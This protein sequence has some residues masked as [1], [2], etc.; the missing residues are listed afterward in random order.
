[1]NAKIKLVEFPEKFGIKKEWQTEYKLRAL[2]I[3][4]KVPVIKEIEKIIKKDKNDYKK[5]VKNIKMQLNSKN[6]LKNKRKVQKGKSEYQENIIEIKA[7]KGHSRLFGFIWNDELII[8]TNTYWKTTSKK[9]KQNKAF[10]RAAE[11]RDL[12]IT[13]KKEK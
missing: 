3:N 8:C 12:F 1:M 2:M 9:K 11:M 6:I 5:L 7:T 10:N 4:N 13:N